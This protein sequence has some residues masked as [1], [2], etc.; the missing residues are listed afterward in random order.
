MAEEICKVFEKKEGSPVTVRGWIYRIRSS[1]RMVFA[2]I[3]DTTGIIQVTFDDSNPRLFETAKKA[4]V[5]SSVII[6]GKVRKDT[7]APGGTEMKGTGLE[8]VHLAKPFP[9]TRDLSDE[10]LLDMR[11]L[12]VRSR[13]MNAT[14]KIRST[15]FGAIHEHMRGDGFYETHSPMFTTAACEGGTT[16]FE[17]PY[18]G[19]KV[20]LSQSWQLYSEAL[21]TTL[22]KIYT[23]APSFRAEKSRTR[24]HLTEFWHAE[25]EAAWYD[26]EDMLKVGEELVSHVARKVAKENKP[27]LE[28]LGQDP[29]KLTRIKPPFRRM[30]YK[31][32][33]DELAEKGIKLKW[34]DDM[35]ADEEK[36]LT[37]D[38][39]KPCYVTNYPKESKGFYFQPDPKDPKTVLGFD[40]LAPG[41]YGE[42]IGGSQRIYDERL[43]EQRLKEEGMSTKN[44]GWYLDLRKYGSVPHSGFG[45]GVDRLIAWLAGS[46]HIKNVIPFPRTINRIRP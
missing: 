5:E 36:V 26:M 15:V 45:L 44:Y 33:L 10:F 1:S 39:K 7:R 41:G 2:V 28:Y 34:G 18:F 32:A 22:E 8:I 11:H 17:V 43:L 4:T 13:E 31:E 12:W 24:R 46:D 30:T 14:L 27:E 3:R 25:V 29:K 21:I 19:Q 9:I 37:G 38:W 42:I 16:L 6:R 35:G 20:Y 40:L 23:V